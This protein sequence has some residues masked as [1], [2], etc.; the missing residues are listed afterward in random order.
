MKKILSAF[1][2][3][4]F[5]ACV[6]NTVHANSKLF[7]LQLKEPGS[8]GQPPEIELQSQSG[9]NEISFVL[10]KIEEPF[11]F[12]SGQQNLSV[13]AIEGTSIVNALNNAVYKST[14]KEKPSIFGKD[15]ENYSPKPGEKFT[16]LKSWKEKPAD[17]FTA[18]TVKLPVKANGLYLLQ[19]SFNNFISYCVVP[20]T[21]I[22]C[23]V[24]RSSDRIFVFAA[25]RMT[26]EPVPSAQ[27]S[28]IDNGNIVAKGTASANGLFD[29]DVKYS[30]SLK[31]F[32]QKDANIAFYDTTS[33]PALT[34][35]M[36]VYLYTERPAYRPSE[37]VFF[38]GTIREFKNSAYNPVPSVEVAIAV[39]DAQ[40][41]QI[42]AGTCTANQYG[43][44]NGEF[45]LPENAGL[46]Q[47]RLTAG[48]NNKT[49]S[50][51]FMI[52]KYQKPEFFVEVRTDKQHYLMNSKI[53]VTVSGQYYFG[54]KTAGA[55]LIYAV[56][57]S[58]FQRPEWTDATADWFYTKN[59]FESTR[60]EQVEQGTGKLD[61]NGEFKITFDAKQ[62]DSDYSYSI[63]AIVTDASKIAV[64]GG[65]NARITKA[66]FALDLKTDKFLYP[67]EDTVKADI[68]AVDYEGRPVTAKVTVALYSITG[69]NRNKTG[70]EM[71]VTTNEKGIAQA[72]I[73]L[74]RTGYHL[75]EVT[76]EDEFKTGILASRNIWVA[77]GEAILGYKGDWIDIVSDKTVYTAGETAHLLILTPNANPYLLLTLEGNRML[78][79]GLRKINGNSFVYDL[80]LT[81]NFSPNVF[82][83]A[84]EA[85][86]KE[87]LTA[88]HTIIVQPVHKLITVSVTPDKTEYK[89]QEQGKLVIKTADAS[90][91]PVPAELSV[92][93]VDESVYAI[94]PELTVPIMKFFYNTRR[95]N[96]STFS[97]AD[98]LS[99]G[100]AEISERLAKA[101]N[102][103]KTPE[104]EK[105][106]AMAAT[107]NRAN[108]VGGGP[109]PSAPRPAP[110]EQSGTPP[111]TGN[112]E[113]NMEELPD[114]TLSEPE[115]DAEEG[116]LNYGGFGY[117]EKSKPG[118]DGGMAPA[119][120][121]K[122]FATTILWE[123]Q[124]IT[125]A[126]G[127]AEITL[128]YPDNLTTWRSTIRAMS[129]DTR[130]GE[131]TFNTKTTKRL[132]LRTA[133]PRFLTQNDR[134][135]L[136]V[137]VHNFLKTAKDVK[138]SLKG[139][140]IEIAGA[141]DSLKIDSGKEGTAKYAL[142]AQKSGNSQI[143]ASALT[144]EDSDAL[145]TALPVLNHGITKSFAVNGV[146]SETQK[147]IPLII[148]SDADADS[149][150]IV[151]VVTPSITAAIMESL[152]Y[153]AEYPYGCTEQTMSRFV[154]NIAAY[155]AMK[156]LNL[157]NK[158]LD[159]ELPKMIEKGLERLYLLQHADGGWGWWEN[160]ATHPFMTAYA[161]TGLSLIKNAGYAVDNERFVKGTQKAQ[162]LL[163]D[164]SI[165]YATRAYL[166]YALYT[167][168]I[169]K[170]NPAPIDTAFDSAERTNA[171][172]YTQALLLIVLNGS[173]RKAEA[174]VLINEL[175]N[176]AQ[177]QDGLLYWGNADSTRW[178]TDNVETTAWAVNALT[179]CGEMQTV[180]SSIKWLML[181]REGAN[182]KSTRD[183][184]A[185]VF[186][187]TNYAV[188][189]GVTDAETTVN[190]TLN[191]RARAGII[192]NK[193]TSIA[194]PF[195][196]G[197][198][199]PEAQKGPNILLLQ[200]NNNMEITY[201][202]YASYYTGQ[203][204]IT[205]QSMEDLSVKREYLRLDPVKDNGIITYKSSPVKDGLKSGDMVL[206][207]LEIS[208]KSTQD[209][210][211]LEDYLPA[212]SQVIEKTGSMKIEGVQDMPD[213]HREN[214]DEK[215]IFFWTNL[216][217]GTKTV[218]YVYRATVAGEFHVMPAQVSL[219]YF[220]DKKA[221]TD[222]LRLKVTE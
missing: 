75:V 153:L 106:S 15:Y 5:I 165:D 12:I 33:F 164:K 108:G 217:A 117:D 159:A 143:N 9:V 74:S 180:Q 89:P 101:E 10:Y 116:G 2:V 4:C 130:V 52:E 168:G 158:K 91:R 150:R 51:E 73:P 88:S 86:K 103:A 87:V 126:A 67:T 63:Q 136:P 100:A 27:I 208:I 105:M 98:Y 22:T 200:K 196:V 29:A 135:T 110:A 14:E 156:Q 131:T 85:Y 176:K 112:I 206:V 13:P 36:K 161:L 83:C 183:T 28:I 16:L 31:C 132:I 43:S 121:R 122:D 62:W 8:A 188:R 144:D 19:A 194:G 195:S 157:T 201:S 93:V 34:D 141:Q 76:A 11:Q 92:G 26:G 7:Y 145:Q 61:D 204:G 79:F 186:A 220:P 72:I 169:F 199:S 57:R 133:L 211:M 18:S 124:I 37:K 30:P 59:E 6:Y 58:K 17:N 151:A 32:V 172:P 140:G 139:T 218:Y 118:K 119:I 221:N 120:T 191:N 123:P 38:K 174:A 148:P 146:L 216:P 102:L 187:F 190:L 55:E 192:I 166:L 69:E 128:K 178:Q 189:N 222:E 82:V 137:I 198:A 182:W 205:A 81:E 54:G 25:D 127:K 193:E 70:S 56:T 185:V 170:E 125:D 50:S 41:T 203:E 68:R 42:Y 109:S 160:D 184:A 53:A 134:M 20:V 66:N 21:D 49:F 114:I 64:S 84:A 95:N 90:G 147:E 115:E 60:P 213:Y 99:Y 181:Q 149:V 209:F 45:Q 154:P 77:K 97:S 171:S 113:G 111:A 129:A 107:P 215:V 212:S 210:L 179:Q 96:I 207:K 65:A 175:K 163:A 177:K 219:M 94:T 142:T 167:A 162:L 71:T 1:V 39:S 214:H 3:F 80:P 46:G 47:C 78:S 48:F 44:F 202:I 152:D 35:H 138:L 173:N 24:K 155:G 23:I 104:G 197:F 40:N